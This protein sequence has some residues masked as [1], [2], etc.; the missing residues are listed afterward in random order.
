MSSIIFYLIFGVTL[1]FIADNARKADLT[2]DRKNT[3]LSLLVLMLLFSLICG[4]RY[5]V[6]VDWATYYGMYQDVL[7]G[8]PLT[9]SELLEK[10]PGFLGIT[11]LMGKLHIPGFIYMGLWAFLEIL[12]L[13]LALKGRYSLMPYACLLL[14]LGPFFLLFMNGMRQ[15]VAACAMMYATKCLVDKKDW[16]KYLIILLLSTLMHKSVLIMLPF[17]LLV[18]YNRLPNKYVCLG[19]LAAAVVA[20]HMPFVKN[21]LAMGETALSLLG[22]EDYAGKIEYYAE[23]GGAISNY[24]PRRIVQLLSSAAVILFSDKIE[25]RNPGDR[26]FKV[27]YLFLLVYATAGEILISSEILFTRPFLYFMPYALVCQAYLLTYLERP[28]GHVTIGKW[29]FRFP[30]S[31]LISAYVIALLVCCSYTVIA[32]LAEGGLPGETVLF[33]FLF[34]HQ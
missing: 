28:E 34:L 18:F 32:N 7:N 25:R 8:S 2:G 30:Q 12:F 4:L 29:Q 27:S 20:G 3:E 21:L 17:L 9:N 11:L 10:E 1:Y 23:A 14:I 15:V 5:R 31:A 16:K 19:L 22:Y 24:G 13:L 26:F 33:K 6:G